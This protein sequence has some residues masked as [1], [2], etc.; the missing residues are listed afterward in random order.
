M[1]AIALGMQAIQ[2]GDSAVVIAGGQENMS[3]A[4]HAVHLRSATKYGDD[5]L[6]DTMRL[7]GLSDAFKGYAMG[8]TAEN[9]AEKYDI[10]RHEQDEFAAQSQQRAE[11][12]QKSDKFADE[13]IPVT[14]KHRKGED[15]VDTDE[16]PRH[17][18]TSEKLSGLPTVFKKDGTV[19][20]G[21]ASTIN[22][23]AAATL[24]MT[25]DRAT[26][27]GLTPLA[28]IVSYATA[29][30]DPSIMGSGPIPA[31][32]AALKRPGWTVDDLDLIESNE[33]FAVQALTVNRELGFDP[34]ITNVN[35]GA[36]ALGH[37]IGASGAR[38]TTTLLHEMK[39][40][41]A[42]RGLATMCIG[43]GMGIALC[44]ELV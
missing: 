13:I 12:A 30:V 41:G 27:N 42:E 2:T 18:T 5:T 4:P 36:I 10:S 7:D 31:T 26:A 29:G 16:G 15:I 3:L 22:D 43:G 19:T 17:G 14:V 37:P 38:I 33:A 35:G 9:L 40:R 8:I 34:D 23:G 28:K 44:V 24:L 6:I 32:R 1:R 39:R 20:P 11:A 25:H 21:N